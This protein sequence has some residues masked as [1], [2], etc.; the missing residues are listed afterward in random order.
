MNTNPNYTYILYG[1]FNKDVALIGK[2][3]EFKTT[4]PQTKDMEWRTFANN[5]KLTYIHTNSTFSSQD[6]NQ[7][8]LINGY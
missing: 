8:I 2:K 3:N 5:L 6:Y 7:T 1:D 4:P